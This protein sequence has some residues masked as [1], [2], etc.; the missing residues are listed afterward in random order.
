MKT[1]ITYKTV[2]TFIQRHVGKTNIS[3]WR[4]SIEHLYL[5]YEHN[6]SQHMFALRASVAEREREREPFP[7]ILAQLAYTICAI[8]LPKFFFLF[9]AF[10][11]NNSSSL[12]HDPIAVVFYRKVLNAYFFLSV[13]YTSWTYFCA[14]LFNMKR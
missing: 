4:H 9:S 1:H 11:H 8:F 13:S 7:Y 12:L 10:V 14:V 5:G 3:I 6:K 2:F